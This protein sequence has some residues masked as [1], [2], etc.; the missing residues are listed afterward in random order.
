MES[1]ILNSNKTAINIYGLTE[2]QDSSLIHF[3]SILYI[4]A[5]HYTLKHFVS[6]LYIHA[7]H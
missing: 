2:L 7:I 5:I 6:I 3:V 4:N 1:L